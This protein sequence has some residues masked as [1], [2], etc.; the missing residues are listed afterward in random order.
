MH[1]PHPV[2]RRTVLRAG[3]LLAAGPLALH[4]ARAQGSFPDKPLTIVVP[5]PAGAS[6]DLLART[7]AVKLTTAFGQ[8]VVVENKS[9]ASGNIGAQHV[10]TGPADGTRILVATEPII[11]V[12]P[13]L[14]TNMGFDPVKDLVPL[15]NGATTVLGLAVHPSVPVNTFPEFLAWAKKQ[16]R[17]FFGTAGAGTPHHINGVI[18][19]QRTGIPME[20]VPYKGSGPMIADLIGGQIKVGISTLSTILPLAREGKLKILGL[21]EKARVPAAPDIPVISEFLPGFTMSSWVGFFAPSATPAPVV[22]RW[23]SEL[24]KALHAPDVNKRLDDAGLP[25]LPANKPEELAA[26]I[27]EDFPRF[28]KV[29]KSSGIRLD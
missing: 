28:G 23:N 13:H 29:I 16:P 10:A 21:G 15:G 7:V 24:M 25:V 19:G 6:T 1:S 11:V 2:N 12:N 5:Y 4:A 22:A 8:P 26:I 20:H 9:G 18:L 17:V 3:A 27:R 14:F